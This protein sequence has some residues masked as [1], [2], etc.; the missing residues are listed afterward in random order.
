MA[1]PT[2]ALGAPAPGTYV[3]MQAP[4]QAAPTSAVGAPAPGVAWGAPPV[5]EEAPAA[6][7][8]AEAEDMDVDAAG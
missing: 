2:A 1:A 5:A 4:G 7:A 6:E 8:V 3:L